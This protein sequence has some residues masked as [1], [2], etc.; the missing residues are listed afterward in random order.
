MTSRYVLRTIF[1][2]VHS[3]FTVRVNYKVIVI[4]MLYEMTQNKTTLERRRNKN[5]NTKWCYQHVCNWTSEHLWM[6]IQ[7]ETSSPSECLYQLAT[8]MFSTFLL[9][10]SNTSKY[11]LHMS[12]FQ[13]TKN[14][15]LKMERNSIFCEFS[16][17][18]V[19]S[20]QTTILTIY[21]PIGSMII[22]ATSHI[23]IDLADGYKIKIQ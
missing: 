1:H 6:K 7:Y 20:I 2:W 9:I 19:N 23:Q 8:G 4:I 21:I 12:V 18:F 13:W 22:P 14:T 17:R 10:T 16:I 15:T 3:T 11:T 5:T